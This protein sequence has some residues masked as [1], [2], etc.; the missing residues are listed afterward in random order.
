MPVVFS[1]QAATPAFQF[2]FPELVVARCSALARSRRIV[3]QVLVLT[4][5]DG[6]TEIAHIGSPFLAVLFEET[7]NHEAVSA[8]DN[9]WLA[10]YDAHDRAP[11]DDPELM[12]WLRQFVATDI[13]EFKPELD[14]TQAPSNGTEPLSSSPT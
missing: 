9:A 14:P 6:T 7:F 12:E 13:A 1:I 8:H 5:R 11:T 3:A 4:R 2:I 10:F